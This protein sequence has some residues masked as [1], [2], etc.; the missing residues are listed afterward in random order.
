MFCFAHILLQENVKND[1]MVTEK[2]L[3]FDAFKDNEMQ[4]NTF[5]LL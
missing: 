5:K 3:N 4:L 1:D 2:I